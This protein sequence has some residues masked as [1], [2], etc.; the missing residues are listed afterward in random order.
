MLRRG[1]T[2]PAGSL[3]APCPGR[4]SAADPHDARRMVRKGGP[5][6]AGFLASGAITPNHHKRESPFM[7]K[8]RTMGYTAP[9]KTKGLR[10]KRS[11]E[12]TIEKR[13]ITP[14]RSTNAAVRPRE[15]LTTE[16]IR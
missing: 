9:M 6:S 8:I 4:N 13:T 11:K 7:T 12:P 1:A 2:P 3:G 15:Y 14:R 16:E 10:V 5:A